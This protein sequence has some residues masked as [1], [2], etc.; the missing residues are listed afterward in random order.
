MISSGGLGLL[1]KI[2]GDSSDGKRA[3]KEFR[4]QVDRDFKA[5]EKD[6]DS[7]GSAN[8]RLS[9]GFDGVSGSAG[10]ASGAMASFVGN[11]AA[12][13]AIQ[14]TDALIQG[15]KILLDYSARLEQ[16]KI[17]FTSLIGSGEKAAKLLKEIQEF[18]KST[19][20]EFAGIASLSQRL[21]GANVEAEKIIPLMR[22]IGNVVAATGETSQARLEGIT[23]ALTQVI[24][25]QKLSAEEAEQFAERGVNAYDLIAKATGK[26]Q[27]EVRKLGEEGKL[28]ADLF[29]ASLKKISQE[30]FGDAMEKQSRT[31]TGALS[32]IKD[33]LLIVATTAFEPLYEKIKTLSVRFADEISRQGNDFGAVGNVIGKYIGEGLGIGL[34]LALEGIG[35]YIGTR[36]AQIFT[37]GKIV[38]PITS[39]FVGGL[40]AAL[41]KA[42]IDFGK[43]ARV[44]LGLANFDGEQVNLQSKPYLTSEELETRLPGANTSTPTPTLLTIPDV[45]KK[46]GKDAAKSV[47]ESF[48]KQFREFAK[49]ID[50]KVN[51][52]FGGAINSGSKHPLGLAG[53]LSIKGK[54]VEEIVNALA[55]GIQKGFRAVDE[56]FVGAIAGVKSTGPNAHFESPGSKKPSL[57][58][59]NRPDLYGGADNLAYLKKL[60]QDRRNKKTSSDEIAEFTKKR[61]DDEKKANEEIVKLRETADKRVLDGAKRA[62]DE[63]KAVNNNL[64]AQKIISQAEYDKRLEQSAIDLLTKEKIL[65]EERL[66][67]AKQ[68]G[69]ETVEIEQQIADIVSK[70]KVKQSEGET[71]AYLKSKKYAEDLKTLRL[72]VAQS[73]LDLFNSRKE[74]QRKDLENDVN[75]SFGGDRLTALVVLKEFELAE[76]LRRQTERADYAK[77]ERDAAL[78]TIEDKVKEK[79]KVEEINKLYQNR[80]DIINNI[81]T[82]DD[83]NTNN[84]LNPAIATQSGAGGLLGILTGGLGDA[85]GGG[86]DPKNEITD[87]VEYMKKVY[88]D[89]RDTAKGAISSMVQGLGQLVSTWITTGKFSGK[90]ALQMASSIITGLAIQ[91]GIKALYELAEGYAM[92]ANPFTAALAPGHFAAAAAYGT[93]AAAAG[94]VGVGLGLASRALG[95]GA[96]AG[97][98]RGGF[99]SAGNG[100]QTSGRGFTGGNYS[101][102]G[103]KVTTYES[104]ANAPFQIVRHEIDLTD[105]SGRKRRFVHNAIKDNV[106]G[107][108]DLRDLF[109][110]MV[111]DF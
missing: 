42:Y 17:G 22:D 1:F 105:A 36:L 97:E 34:S 7:V 94:A 27:T 63:E 91:A 103:D 37:E 78:L 43:R 23:V 102:E 44:K 53:D 76:N 4:D 79:E 88:T 81:H 24:G 26:T 101:R 72:E 92:L 15:G 46:S 59:E 108:G 45:G 57:F 9:K 19:P 47:G 71:A 111:N 32:N 50:F 104:G 14:F 62:A 74:G 30:K 77:R 6:V 40:Y 10:K 110:K 60:D 16:T 52:T 29:V 5:V 80:L 33:S 48:D 67:L 61:I 41:D 58:I 3:I 86:V 65:L 2:K 11:L 28:S 18:A 38:D 64:L 73:E 99:G 93:V 55:Q 89:L 54:S 20:F 96:T 98:S 39:A 31:F 84:D 66:A 68:S 83:E 106:D 109:Q 69:V 13:A 82:A 90:A 87:K 8:S 49:E 100:E 56:R 85:A 21:L 51:R 35:T 95:G 25:K 70:I 107:N 75:K 12:N